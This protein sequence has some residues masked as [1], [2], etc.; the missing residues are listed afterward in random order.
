MFKK[1]ME[2]LFCRGW[3]LPSGPVG[4][5]CR[6]ACASQGTLLQAHPTRIFHLP[7]AQT[8]LAKGPISSKHTTKISAHFLTVNDETCALCEDAICGRQDR[9]VL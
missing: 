8:G 2:L 4:G 3:W 5:V 9:R 7:K 1:Q 6:H